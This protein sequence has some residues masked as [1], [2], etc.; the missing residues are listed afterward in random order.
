MTSSN[1]VRTP[2]RAREALA[3][4]LVSLLPALK[5][6]FQATLPEGVRDE[7]GGATPHQLEALH[8][9]HLTVAAG[10]SAR[11]ATM[12]ELARRQG[13]AMSTATALADRLLRQGLVVRVTDDDDRRVVRIAPTERGEAL[14]NQFAAAKRELALAATAALSDDELETLIRLFR[15]VAG[16]EAAS[17][18]EEETA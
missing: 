17:C 12:N 10:D 7:L 1:T 9:L 18:G 15:K 16:P 8:L 13:C 6:R 4:E 11:G 14:C 3:A 5:H 2:S